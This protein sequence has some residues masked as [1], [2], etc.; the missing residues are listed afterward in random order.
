M[1]SDRR[2]ENGDETEVISDY[3]K[4]KKTNMFNTIMKRVL[5]FFLTL[6][7]L[8]SVFSVGT[9]VIGVRK[10][11]T[12]FQ[13]TVAF[14]RVN[15]T[16]GSGH[17]Y[18]D[19]RPLTEVDTQAS[20]RLASEVA[21]KELDMNCS[22]HD[23][24]YVIRGQFPMIGGPSAG[25][26]MTAMS[27]CE[28]LNITPYSNVVLTGTINPDGSIGPV[29]GVFE[30]AITADSDGVDLFLIPVGQAYE[31]DTNLTNYSF[32]NNMKVIEVSTIEDAFYY[33]TGYKIV[34]EN[35]TIN[36]ELYDRIMKNMADELIN[37]NSEVSEEFSSNLLKTNLS[38]ENKTLLDNIKNSTIEREERMN[39]LY[40]EGD[41]YSAASYAVGNSLNN[42]Y[43]SYLI[44]YFS[45]NNKTNYLFS[46]FEE[47]EEYLEEVEKKLYKNHNV[48]NVN[49]L[50][51]INIA[52]DRY[53]EAHDLYISANNTYYNNNTPGTLYNLA[54][55]KVRTKTADTWITLIDELSGNLNITFNVD[56]FESLALERMESA[57]NMI[58]YAE[59]MGP[60]YYLN[61]AKEHFNKA[62]EA[63]IS[64][65]YVYSIFESLRSLS[66]SNLAMQLRGLTPEQIN[67]RLN[68]SEKLAREGIR[69]AQKEGLLPILA[70][71]Y[72]EYS[73]T[74]RETDSA[75]S[76]IFLEYS[77]QF[78]KLSL[79]MGERAGNYYESD[80]VSIREGRI[81]QQNNYNNITNLLLG[82]AIGLVFSA[83]FI[84]QVYKKIL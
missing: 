48:D 63:F 57:S 18:V 49:D 6:C 35:T 51:S 71:S 14:L 62:E 79:S 64:G 60:N 65:K 17:V 53:N 75:Q 40:D 38:K 43:A 50:E 19:T 80:E 28:L 73:H 33:I 5:L 4:N 29:G 58:T 83:L 82:F 8:S 13:G 56:E 24:F 55:T 20:A 84:E 30:K 2:S 21:C 67:Y 70:L 81:F 68:L 36:Y 22:N 31:E 37:Y 47:N 41:Y 54:F 69:E 74:F 44:N 9:R 15:V 61:T 10:T 3:K 66:A 7:A 23:F 46:L 11:S 1:M 59:T 12:G 42:L 25:A 39:E 78:S 34:E 45:S 77:K 27:M 16:S 52:I 76:L 32:P 26:A 72:L